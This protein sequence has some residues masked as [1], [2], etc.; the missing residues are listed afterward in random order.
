MAFESYMRFFEVPC[1]LKG[2]EHPTD[3]FS[4]WVEQKCSFG[5]SVLVSKFISTPMSIAEADVPVSNVM[6]VPVINLNRF[7]M[8]GPKLQESPAQVLV[9][10]SSPA[11]PTLHVMGPAAQLDQLGSFGSTT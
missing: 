10:V 9:T 3:M 1:H 5:T 6:P 2:Y 8:H 4:V 7:T 11:H